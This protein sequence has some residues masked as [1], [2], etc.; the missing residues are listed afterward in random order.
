VNEA[1][2]T[3]FSTVPGIGSRLAN[4]II[5]FREKLG[6]FY[7]ADQIGETYNLPDST[8]QKIKPFLKTGDKTVKKIN[9]NT[10]DASTLKTHP[11]IRW[12]LANAIVQYRT[13]H[14]NYKSVDDLKQ[15]AII[16]PEIFQKISP[17]LS[18]TITEN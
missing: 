13:Q 18:T 14:G 8:F 6:G 16:T 11:Y 1:D 4:R 12:N 7:S 2:S 15:I 3:A 17:Y 9:I 5:G 10:A